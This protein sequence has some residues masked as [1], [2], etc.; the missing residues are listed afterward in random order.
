MGKIKILFAISLFLLF[1]LIVGCRKNVDPFSNT[2]EGKNGITCSISAGY[3]KNNLA[4]V[5]IS[6]YGADGSLKG[7]VSLDVL[8]Y[9]LHIRRTYAKLKLPS[10][11]AIELPSE[12]TQ[13]FEIKDGVLT[14][15]P[16]HIDKETFD[17]FFGKYDRDD[18]SLRG[19]EKFL[20]AKEKAE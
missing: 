13:I 14:E 18:Y 10:G 19:L 6:H 1:L 16:L 17:E 9:P 7:G 3:Y 15:S 4:Y 2:R 20:K 11:E 8:L 12:K 5:V